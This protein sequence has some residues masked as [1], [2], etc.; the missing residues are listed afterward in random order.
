MNAYESGERKNI[1]AVLIYVRHQGQTLMIHRN[2]RDIKNDDHSGKWNGLGGKCEKD[3]SYL[4]AAQREL[5]EE[6]GLNVLSNRFQF[7][8]FLQF[9]NFKAN[10]NQDWSVM[11]FTVEVEA[12]EVQT[13]TD[14]Q[15]VRVHEGTLHWINDSEISALNLWPGDRYFI[16]HVINSKPFFGSIMYEGPEVIRAHVSMI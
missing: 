12:F 9:P 15:G 5:K 2:T 8:G 13:L 7:V 6:S 4:E 14:P 10:K 1:P 3:E 16:D 11:V